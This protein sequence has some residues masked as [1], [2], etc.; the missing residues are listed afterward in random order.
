L[1]LYFSSGNTILMQPFKIGERQHTA[2]REDAERRYVASV[3]DFLKKNV[4]EAAEDKPEALHA[5]VAA[6]VKRAKSY[7]MVTKP[8]AAVYVTTSYLLGENFEDHFKV[9]REVLD[10]SLPAP[11][12]AE[13]LQ[14]A[15]VLLLLN[16]GERKQN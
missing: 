13:W 6:M 1:K 10:S 5:F 2:F 8:D 14:Q 12:K 15:T 11:D 9:A 7:G 16:A 3:A 4:A